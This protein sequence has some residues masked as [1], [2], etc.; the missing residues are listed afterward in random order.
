MVARKRAGPGVAAFDVHDPADQH[1]KQN[2]ARN[3]LLNQN[4]S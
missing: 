3:K 4:L 1:S 2:D